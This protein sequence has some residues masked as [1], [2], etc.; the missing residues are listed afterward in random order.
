MDPKAGNTESLVRSHLVTVSASGLLTCAGGK[1][2]T[3]R[4]M[5]EDAVDEAIKTFNLTPKHIT[6][7]DISGAGRPGFTT[8]GTCVTRFTPILGSHGYSTQLPSQLTEV[9][10]VDTD[11][12][13]HLAT[14][15]GDRA[16]SVLGHAAGPGSGTARLDPSFPFI[17][18]E[19]RHAVRSE[20]AYTAA[21]AIARRTR[22]AFLNVDAA[23]KALPRIVDI[24]AEELDWSEAR[25]E[26]EW[27]R[28][29]RFLRSMGL[30]EARL[31]V[32]REEVMGCDAKAR[33]MKQDG[34]VRPP[35]PVTSKAGGGRELGWATAL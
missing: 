5:A 16:W 17:E 22:L 26:Q 11:I 33:R 8:N 20:A 35:G 6:L 32:T 10:G 31:A 21:D 19:I 9:Y 28:T 23:L 7:P 2:T 34:V 24:M 14:N 15:Y 13:H 30:E 29:V 3:Y 27:T 12:A 4:Q 18:A 25:R 1:W